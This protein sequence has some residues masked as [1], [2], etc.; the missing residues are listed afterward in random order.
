[1]DDNTHIISHPII[2]DRLGKLR[3]KSCLT[4]DF[5]RN[6]TEI[7]RILAIYATAQLSLNPINIETP[8]TKTAAKQLTSPS[9]L[10]VPILRAG[11]A[12]SDGLQDVLP[13]ADTAHIGLY[14]DEDTLLP[15]EY[16][17]KLPK[18]L[19]RSIFIC[20][21]MLATAGSMI[22]T[23]NIL[24]K[25]GARIQDITLITLVCAPE[26]IT[27]LREHFP[28][29]LLYTAAIDNH[30]NDVGYIVPGLGDAGDRFF[31]T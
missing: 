24:L 18:N 6:V 25:R 5:R 22:E 12:L 16:L 29:V 30:L 19:A 9:P 7:S 15:V 31:G 10:I 1:M 11:L 14:R 8:I 28:N 17:T 2:A 20:D 4:H 26:G 21:P 23:I 3:D 13:E 27:N